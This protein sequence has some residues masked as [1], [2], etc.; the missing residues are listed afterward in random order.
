V[1]GDA[2]DAAEASST[3][4]G[5][6]E[7]RNLSLAGSADSDADDLPATVDVNANGFVNFRAD[8]G[9]ALGKFWR[10]ETIAR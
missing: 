5:Q 4:A 10:G 2:A 1:G 8:G 7:W 6:F 9:C 3:V